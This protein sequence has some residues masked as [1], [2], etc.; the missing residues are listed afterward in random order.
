[1]ELDVKKSGPSSTSITNSEIPNRRRW[2]S[3]TYFDD[4]GDGQ[5]G[6]GW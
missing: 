6:T 3:M 5:F 2:T 4:F 1:M